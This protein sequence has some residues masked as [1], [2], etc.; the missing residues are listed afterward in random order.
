MG[1]KIPLWLWGLLLIPGIGGC[2]LRP[3]RQAETII[4]SAPMI[5][6]GPK[7]E[8][9]VADPTLMIPDADRPALASSK[10][11][12]PYYPHQPL[13]PAAAQ[14]PVPQA[15]KK[16]K[17][18]R[19]PKTEDGLEYSPKMGQELPAGNNF[20]K[21]AKLPEPQ[22][23]SPGNK[24]LPTQLPTK[25]VELKPFEFNPL[26]QKQDPPKNQITAKPFPIV[27]DSKPA[28]QPVSPPIPIT[29][30]SKPAPQP[31]SPPMNLPSPPP[32]LFGSTKLPPPAPVRPAQPDPALSQ[33]KPLLPPI[34]PEQT[35]A[36]LALPKQGPPL[37]KTESPVA[38]ISAPIAAPTQDDPHQGFQPPTIQAPRQL[39]N[40]QVVQQAAP[41]Q[42]PEPPMRLAP[43]PQGGGGL[44]PV[45]HVP[46]GQPAGSL[47]KLYELA[48]ESYA[49]IDSYIVR[50]R[51][52]EFINNKL[53]PE[54][55]MMFKFRKEP[56]SVYLKWLGT[57]HKDREVIFVQGKHDNKI[58]TLTAAGDIPFMPAGHHSA[59]SPDN[60]LVRANSRHSIREAGIGNVI[61]EFGT[62]VNAVDQGDGRMGTLK[63]LG[64]VT[65]PEFP[66]E[67]EAVLHVLPPGA[68][69]HLPRGGE[70]FIYFDMNLRFPVLLIARDHNREIVEYYCYD[71]F[72]FPGQVSEDEFNPYVLWKK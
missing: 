65:R 2:F 35:I 54:E 25:L 68:D 67:V 64:K 19:L 23:S 32:E 24:T 53:Q 59:L 12:S 34:A 57:A 21:S 33:A 40:Y 46:K 31:V 5:S 37:V 14:D 69:K 10:K 44:Q 55:L 3:N 26:I 29:E 17:Y 15:T 22:A 39:P 45:S 38:T 41:V 60:P 70:R 28:P 7:S 58:H 9:P 50:F 30:D 51:R 62:L 49:S 13:S 52:R 71:R 11:I 61:D 48:A 63:Y 27:E 43:I 66:S 72:L 36:K 1:N 6:L 16:L 47:R 4:E 18:L 42:T 8:L 20:P 56:F